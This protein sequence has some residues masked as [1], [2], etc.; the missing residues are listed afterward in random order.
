MDEAMS[1]HLETLMRH[2]AMVVDNGGTKSLTPAFVKK[3]RK[4]TA[5]D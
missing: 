1:R 5:L 2:G 4:P 3:A